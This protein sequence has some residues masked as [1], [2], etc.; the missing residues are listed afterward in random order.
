MKTFS[1]QVENS[2]ETLIFRLIFQ[3]FLK[4]LYTHIGMYIYTYI[5]I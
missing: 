5:C 2:Y 3:L 1:E 4:Y